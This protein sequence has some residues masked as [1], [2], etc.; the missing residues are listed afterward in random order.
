[1]K[2][3]EKMIENSIKFVN[4]NIDKEIITKTKKKIFYT[5]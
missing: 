4:I 5:G 2:K 1:M 3:H